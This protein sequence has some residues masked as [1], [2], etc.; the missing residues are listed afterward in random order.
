MTKF[1][2]RLFIV[3]GIL[4][5]AAGG[6]LTAYNVWDDYRASSAAATVLKEFNKQRDE[7]IAQS[8]AADDSNSDTPF[9][10]WQEEP[11]PDYV[12][13][14]E[15]PMPTITID[16]YKYVGTIAI[17]PLELELPVTEEWDYDRMKIA[18]CRY[19]GSVYLDNMVICGHNYKS[20]FRDLED[21]QVNDEIVFIDAV[22]NEFHYKVEYIDTLSATAVEDMVSSDWDFTLFTCNY[23]GNAR[24]TIRCSRTDK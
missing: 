13:D 12:L 2:I 7:L 14:P 1:K 24:V 18:A 16:N 5:I 21:L 10:E 4:L 11:L 3:S 19:S 6:A 8:S 17:P 9:E 15:M 22:G 23:I 20:Q